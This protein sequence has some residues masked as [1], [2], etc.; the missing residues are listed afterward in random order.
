MAAAKT[1]DKMMRV[2]KLRE[3]FAQLPDVNQATLRFIFAHLL[4]VVSHEE[5]NKMRMNNVAIVFGKFPH[6]EKAHTHTHT[7]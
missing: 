4:R 3:L 5:H 1:G 6:H 7:H 2:S